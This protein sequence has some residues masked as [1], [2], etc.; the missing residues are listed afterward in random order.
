[1]L[2]FLT[3]EYQTW[4]DSIGLYRVIQVLTQLE[5][6]AFA[7]VLFA[8]AIVLIAGPRTIVWLRRRKIGDN[9]EFFDDTINKLS[10]DKRGTPTMGGLLICGAI[11][12]SVALFAD[13]VHSKY[14]LLT[15]VTLVWFG[16]IG[17][18]DDWLK[19][20]A[21]RRASTTRHGLRTKEKLLLQTGGAL[22]IAVALYFAASSDTNPAAVSFNFPFQRTYE[23]STRTALEGAALN[24]SVWILG[25][26]AFT[27]IG[28]FWITG[29]SNCVNLTDG[30]DGL[31]AGT[32]VIASFVMM[33][34]CF[35]AAS[36]DAA[37]F[38]MVPHVPGAGELMVVA[39]AM[40]GACLGFLWFNCN[41]ARVFMGDTGSL[42]LGALLAVIAVAIRQEALL[43]V[44]GGVFVVEGA[45]VILQ[46]SFFKLSGGVR[47]F[48]MAPIH[49]T[50]QKRGW[51]ETQVVIRF[52]VIGIILG[53][54]ALASV[55][56]R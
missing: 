40:A 1:V 20:E 53:M 36:R 14:V 55:K 27:A 26:V 48:P 43:V 25:I 19:L 42:P 9:P 46:V 33:V 28:A 54:L 31:A 15:V 47:I 13:I 7:A 2:Y 22:L 50:F 56:M 52:W 10:Q 39:G 23:P 45:S 37:F 38:L 24:P 16:G 5:F 21:A 30:L 41:P 8:F 44:L 51:A 6:R 12:L 3:Q 35:V 29:F 32:M 4:L 34:L 49:H 18:F 17:F 11:F